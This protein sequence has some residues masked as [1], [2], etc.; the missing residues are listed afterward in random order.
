MNKNKDGIYIYNEDAYKGIK[1]ACELASKTLDM[2]GQ[3]IE[4]K[5][6]K[7]SSNSGYFLSN[8]DLYVQFEFWC[9]QNGHQAWLPRNFN[10]ALKEKG[11][12]EGRQ[13]QARGF[14]DL[15]YK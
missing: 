11:F 12:E 2:I 3:F 15:R 5:L 10:R 13:S 14:L 9:S 4:E 1:K 6:E 7:L 8:S